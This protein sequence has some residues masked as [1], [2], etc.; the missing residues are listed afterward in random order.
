MH[1]MLLF[2]FFGT[3]MWVITFVYACDVFR[4]KHEKLVTVITLGSLDRRTA[5]FC[6]LRLLTMHIYSFQN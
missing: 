4:R 3:G 2:V 5:I 1:E 6:C